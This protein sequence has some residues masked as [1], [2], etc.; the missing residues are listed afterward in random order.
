MSFSVSVEVREALSHFAEHQRKNRGTS[1]FG[2]MHVD[3]GEGR[4][5]TAD[6]KTRLGGA[7]S[8]HSGA[9]LKP[10]CVL[11]YSKVS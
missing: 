5:P 4:K 2:F 11:Q 7:E 8:Q 6:I 10:C 9:S 1:F 3:E